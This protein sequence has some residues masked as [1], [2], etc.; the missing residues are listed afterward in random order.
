LAHF[1]ALLID[2]LSTSGSGRR[3]CRLATLDESALTEGEVDLRVAYSG[4]NAADALALAEPVPTRSTPCASPLV[5]GMDLAGTVVASRLPEW[6]PG[7][8][9]VATGWGLGA[10]HHGGYAE[11]AR[12]WG[13]WLLR[14]PEG[15][16]LAQCMAVGTEGLAAMLGILELEGRAVEPARGPVAVT[17]AAGGTGSVAVALLGRLGFRVV[18][19]TAAR[20]GRRWAEEA[21]YL[22]RLGAAEVVDRAE[23]T[24]S[25]RA[26]AEPEPPDQGRWIGG[27]DAAGGRALAGLLA[28]TG[29]GGTVACSASGA[30]GGAYLPATSLAPFVQR[31][32]TLIGVDA[33]RAARSLRAEAWDRIATDLDPG[34]LAAMT[35]TVD[36][37]DVAGLAPALLAGRVRGRVV[38]RV[39][40]ASA[41]PEA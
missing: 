8:L 36:L 39:G 37:K 13:R 7:D 3:A 33:V 23:L 10:T 2:R 5:P 6:R 14:K 26:G 22:R 19:I 25:P 17:A 30:G 20:A 16:S 40:A 11:H 32:V 12:V 24:R 31:A 38:V 9:V 1:R 15:L 29:C 34:L 41:D 35:T 4:V 28:R 18:A 21:G 27:I